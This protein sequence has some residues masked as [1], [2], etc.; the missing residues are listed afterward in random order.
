[1]YNV[2]F[3]WEKIRNFILDL[4]FPKEC[5]GCKEEGV[6]LCQQCWEKI[7]LN[8]KFYCVFCKKESDLSKVCAECKKNTCLNAVWLAADY[9]NELIQKLIHNF[10]YNYLDELDRILADL[11]IRYLEEN[12]I[13]ENANLQPADLVLVPVPLHKKRF[14][15]RGFNQSYLLAKKVSDF[16]KIPVFNLLLRNKNTLSQVN[17]KRQERQENLQDAFIFNNNIDILPNK[18]AILIDDVVT[19]GSTLKECA[20]VLRENGFAEIY[21]LVIAQRED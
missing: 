15:Q 21:G 2:Q 13:F 17:L 6:Y 8:S 7:K 4:I 16:Y 3:R 5:L 1:M 19:T 20:R 18:K 11:I 14:L 12:K 9:N 10:K